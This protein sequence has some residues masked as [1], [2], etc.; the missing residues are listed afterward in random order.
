ML[1]HNLETLL[2]ILLAQTLFALICDL[3]DCLHMPAFDCRHG[4]GTLERAHLCA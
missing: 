1:E 3:A 4:L 2:L